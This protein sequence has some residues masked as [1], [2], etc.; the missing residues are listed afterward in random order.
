MIE[1]NLEKRTLG[2][3]KKSENGILPMT[4]FLLKQNIYILYIHEFRENRSVQN[5]IKY[6]WWL[7]L[8]EKKG[9]TFIFYSGV[10]TAL[11]FD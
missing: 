2:L 8:E 4:S 5:I 9:V 10:K 7:D 1:H 11:S 6:C 3:K